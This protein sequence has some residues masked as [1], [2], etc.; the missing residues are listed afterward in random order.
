MKIELR[1]FRSDG[2]GDIAY[3]SRGIDTNAPPLTAAADGVSVDPA[4]PTTV[5][6]GQKVGQA[7][8]PAILT[9][10]REI[11]NPGNFTV[12]FGRNNGVDDVVGINSGSGI[13]IDNASGQGILIFCFGLNWNFAILSATSLQESMGSEN[14]TYNDVSKRI[15]FSN[16]IVAAGGFG[17]NIRTTNAAIINV[18]AT[19]FTIL[20]D[21]SGGNVVVNLDPAVL[22]NQIVNIKKITP[23]LN[24]ITLTP[25]SGTIQDTGVPTA[26]LVF[27]VEGE[28]FTIHCDGTNFY[29]I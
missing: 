9:E 1:V 3:N 10:D 14:W 25:T 11:P 18:A 22:I 15:T 7:G 12:F 6:L 5:R 8:D 20:S 23:D 19:D 17:A 13:S 29:I 4:T 21:T 24:T 27:N 26:T 28:S 16:T 2:L